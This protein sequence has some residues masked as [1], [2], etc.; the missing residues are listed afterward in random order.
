MRLLVFDPVRGAAGDMITGALLHVGAD[1]D[2]TV[3]AM[4]SVV[5]EPQISLVERAGIRSIQVK[6]RA[7]PEKRTFPEVIRRVKNARASDSAIA[8]AVR[9]FERIERA[10]KEVHGHTDHFHEVGADDAVAEVVGAC[11]AFLS[12][13]VDG[14]IVLPVMLG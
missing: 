6:T 9:V 13:H 10:E 11:T 14:C 7:T 12:L 1:R 8:M 4:A 5:G 3:S 2:A